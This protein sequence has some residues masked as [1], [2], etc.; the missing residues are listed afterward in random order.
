M[1]GVFGSTAAAYGGRAVRLVPKPVPVGG[2]FA[3]DGYWVWCGSVIRGD[4]G[5][6]HMFASRWS[7]DVDFF[8]WAVSSEIVRAVADR[9]EG[10]FEFQEVVIG[11]RGESF[12]DGRVAHNPRVFRYGD[13][14]VLFYVGATFRG[15]TPT[16]AD[17][18]TWAGRRSMES[19]HNKRVGMATAPSLLGPWTR[20]DEPV[21]HPRTGH[22]DSVIT[23]NPATCVDEDG[24]ILL[25]YKST[26]ARHEPDGRF[27]GRFR[28]GVARAE[29]LGAPFK[30]LSDEPILTFADPTAHVEDPFVW[31]EPGR[32]CAIMKDM[33]GA[34]GGDP[35]AGVAATSV[36][37]V[38][39]TLADPPQA[40]PRTLRWSDGRTTRPAKLERPQLLIEDGRPTHLYLATCDNEVDLRQA[41]RTWSVAVPLET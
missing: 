34:I 41:T 28:L 25:L 22:W 7:Q 17:P 40:Y 31:R 3:M 27:L 39:W 29:R 18:G 21:L 15:P 11:P 36:D 8:H 14:Y 9:P 10:P 35:G 32:F 12:F 2:G 37:G 20:V 13:G 1:S 6:Y 5:R 24:G 19:W 16:A 23:S 26:D 33:T 4:D 30:R 38:R